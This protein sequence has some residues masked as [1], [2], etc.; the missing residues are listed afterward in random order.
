MLWCRQV[1]SGKGFQNLT[2]RRVGFTITP[3]AMYAH[4][5]NFLATNAAAS[6]ANLSSVINGV[7]TTPELRWANPLELKNAVEKALT[8]KFGAK[9]AA[10]PK[11]KVHSSSIH[12]QHPFTRVLAGTEGEHRRQFSRR[13]IGPRRVGESYQKDRLRGGFP[14]PASQ[15]WGEPSNQ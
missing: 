8:E 6:W 9:E 5:T 12:S 15:T 10:K 4:V 11:A 2:S 13:K 3:E 7:K 1:S 14:R